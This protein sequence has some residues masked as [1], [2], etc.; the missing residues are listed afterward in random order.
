M[1]RFKQSINSEHTKPWVE[2][3]GKIILNF[4][5][6]EMESILWLVQ[7]SERE[8]EIKTIAE[9]PLASRITQIIRHIEER[10]IGVQWRKK[11]LRAW[12]EALK[13]AHLRNQV[14]HNPVIF[15]WSKVP[16]V[17][18]PDILGIPNLRAASSKKAQWQLSTDNADKS[19]DEIV[20]I[21]QSLEKLRI[22][23]CAA[24]DQGKA[25]PLKI[26]PS[27]WYKFKR[28]VGMVIYKLKKH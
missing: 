6:V 16:E 8:F 18:I 4:S 7:L 23:W 13:L 3:I 26:A 11:S 15:G 10:T 17:G 20:A 1:T 12:N 24:R 14:A 19:I 27:L 25:P 2:R 9:M 22:D 21:A 5:V 28:R